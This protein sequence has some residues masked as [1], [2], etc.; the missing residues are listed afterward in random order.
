MVGVKPDNENEVVELLEVRFGVND[1]REVLV[2]PPAEY[3]ACW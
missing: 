1:R 2:R 3:G